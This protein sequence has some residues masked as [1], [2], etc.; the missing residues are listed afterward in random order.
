MTHLIGAENPADHMKKLLSGGNC[1]N[2]VQNFM[3]KIDDNDLHPY[4][5]SE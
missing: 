1:Q 2:P 5:V 4:P 3:H